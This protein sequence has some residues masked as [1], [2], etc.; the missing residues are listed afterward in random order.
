MKHIQNYV[1]GLMD[2]TSDGGQSGG[3]SMIDVQGSEED[4]GQEDGGQGTE[5][6]EG[7]FAPENNPFPDGP[8]GGDFLT[9]CN[10]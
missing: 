2:P 9:S 8:D 6:T 4:G 10:L 7:F 5:F 3:D 1:M